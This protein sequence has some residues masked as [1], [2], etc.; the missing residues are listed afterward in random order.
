MTNI[1]KV[2]VAKSLELITR[3]LKSLKKFESKSLE[4]YLGTF[5]TQMV[6]EKLLQLMT[7]LNC[8]VIA[9]PQDNGERQQFLS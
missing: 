5:E 8:R 1:D 4:E 6:V 3:Y 7:Q 9:Q 2:I